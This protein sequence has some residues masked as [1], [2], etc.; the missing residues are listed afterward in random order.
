MALS[1]TN[2]LITPDGATMVAATARRQQ[3][4]ARS[5]LQFSEFS[6]RTGA[7]AR[8]LARWRLSRHA[9]TWQDVLWTR[10]SGRTLIVIPRPA[11]GL[12]R[13]H[14]TVPWSGHGI[15]TSGG[16]FTPLPGLSIRSSDIAW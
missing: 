10:S 1:G 13:A 6:A 8:A 5:D 11:P 16:Q 14:S 7:V 12:A 15:L 2:A 3:R 4:P 9:V